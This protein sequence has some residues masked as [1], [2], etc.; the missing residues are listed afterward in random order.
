MAA[1]ADK[2]HVH[3][4]H[5]SNKLNYSRAEQER[6][7]AEKLEAECERLRKETE[8][9]TFRKKQSNDHK[10]SLRLSEIE[11]WKKELEEKIAEDV[12]ET[13]MLNKCKEQLEKALAATRFPLEVA[14]KCLAFR[15]KRIS[16]DL[17]HDDVEIQLLKVCLSLARDCVDLQLSCGLCVCRCV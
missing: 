10:F 16:I 8:A 15:E 7:S 4:W 5:A 12:E 2:Y 1:T 14:Q 17:V 11:F 9:T 6:A 13:K 3:E